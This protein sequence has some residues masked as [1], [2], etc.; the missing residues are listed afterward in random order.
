MDI[1][2]GDPQSPQSLH[3][4]LY[5]NADPVNNIDPSG[6]QLLDL[7]F[8]S[9]AYG[10]AF[11]QAAISAV[12]I[13]GRIALILLLAGALTYTAVQVGHYIQASQAARQELANARTRVQERVEE[14]S[15]K[16]K[17]G[18]LFHY[19]DAVSAKLIASTSMMMA[20]AKYIAAGFAFLPGVYATGVPPWTPDVRQSALRDLFYGAKAGTQDVSWYVAICGDGFFPII[21]APAPYGSQYYRPAPVGAL[22]PVE[23]LSVGPNLMLP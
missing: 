12:A 9:A 11:A 8:G 10:Y 6:M 21:G 15:K 19:T 16:C 20:S 13:L 7:A 23:V 17:S 22:V 4:Y 18:P 14:E 1:L 3:R 5:V 2:P